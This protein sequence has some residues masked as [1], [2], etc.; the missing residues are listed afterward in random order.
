MNTDIEIKPIVYS[1]QV[2]NYEY[3]HAAS[4]IVGCELVWVDTEVYSAG[5]F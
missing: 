3:E 4:S 5:S 1:F 2:E